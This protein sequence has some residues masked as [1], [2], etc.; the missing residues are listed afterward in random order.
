[1]PDPAHDQP[2]RDGDQPPSVAAVVG[3]VALAHW[4]SAS[5]TDLGRPNVSTSR[6]TTRPTPIATAATASG[7]T[8]RWVA[9]A[10]RMARLTSATASTVPKMPPRRPNALVPASR[11]APSARPVRTRE[12]SGGV[13]VPARRAT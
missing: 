7:D 4:S 9:S 8:S 6:V 10:Y 5:R 1:A 13:R 12:L 11:A 2:A 3:V